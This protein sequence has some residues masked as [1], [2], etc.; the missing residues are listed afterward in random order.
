M[1]VRRYANT[2]SSQAL[3]MVNDKHEILM[4]EQ[5]IIALLVSS[6]NTTPSRS[7]FGH[8]AKGSEKCIVYSDISR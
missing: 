5:N 2:P 3:T 1:R 4:E 7:L 6:R 8:I